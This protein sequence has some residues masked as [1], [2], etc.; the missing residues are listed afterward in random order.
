MKLIKK[1]EWKSQFVF[2]SVALLILSQ[3][4]LT[5]YDA[6]PMFLTSLGIYLYLY[7]EKETKR[8]FQRIAYAIITLAGL[9][10]LYPFVILPILII[11]EYRL[12]RYN[13]L[14]KNIIVCVIATLPFL[15]QVLSG[16]DGISWF[17]SYHGDRGLEIESTYS[18]VLLLLHQLGLIKD[19]SIVYTH[20]SYGISGTLP[21]FFSSLSLIIF[22]VSYFVLMLIAFFQDWNKD[23]SKKIIQFSL[24]TIG[25]F[26]LTNKVFS[27][28]YILWFFPYLSITPFLYSKK[29]NVVLIITTL[30]SCILTIMIYP[31]F[32]LTFNK[33]HLGLTTILLIRNILL[34]AILLYTIYK[35]RLI[36]KTK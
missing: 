2:Q 1:S 9:T 7:S 17:L 5:K 12:K 10:K 4:L 25:T 32:W 27:A 6:F 23:V 16:I 21:N 11:R 28:Q 14:I 22:L 30:L 31:I 36:H 29:T 18:S 34:V 33:G 15:I 35:L 24:L 26:V 20:A 13:D 19:I 8:L 3:L